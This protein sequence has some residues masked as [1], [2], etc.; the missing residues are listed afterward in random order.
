MIEQLS[1]KSR[2]IDSH[3]TEFQL[4]VSLIIK[5]YLEVEILLQKTNTTLNEISFFRKMF[6][7]PGL[8]SL[9]VLNNLPQELYFSFSL[10]FVHLKETDILTCDSV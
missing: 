6:L 1:L 10:K 5:T 4:Q 3:L 7:W 9:S 2:S 8:R